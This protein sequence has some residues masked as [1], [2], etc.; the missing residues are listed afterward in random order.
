MAPKFSIHRLAVHYVDRKGNNLELAPT[1]LDIAQLE[2][3]VIQFLKSLMV[4]VWDAADSKRTVSA[5]YSEIGANV[6]VF[7][8]EA[9][10][11]IDDQPDFYQA[12]VRIARHLYAVTPN[13]ASDG[14]LVVSRVVVEN[15]PAYLV[16]LK[17]YK[18][19]ESFVR[20][21]SKN[22]TQITVEDVENLLDAKVQKAAISPHPTKPKF[23]VKVTDSQ[24]KGIDDPPAEY[25]SKQF[26]GLVSKK[27][28]DH[29][30]GN[31]VKHL[32]AYS[33]IHDLP[34]KTENTLPFF[35][36]LRA[37][38]RN[39]TSVFAATAAIESRLYGDAQIDRNDLVQFISSE[40]RLGELDIPQ[41]VLER[42]TP[43]NL[44]NAVITF[45]D[46]NLNKIRIVGPVDQ[47][48]RILSVDDG[49][50]QAQIL[51]RTLSST[52][53]IDYEK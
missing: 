36:R 31:L 8:T 47:L 10:A 43:K 26:L 19:D 50:N 39:V 18:R 13:Q 29:Q 52:I 37:E 27:S 53:Q 16:I 32:R 30:V 49:D 24:L 38:N 28:D 21:R 35:E 17:I 20:L 15:G 6:G 3:E 14:L 44:R 7:R 33:P 40:D 22:L 23:H 42:R 2:E 11:I 5:V 34:Y 9:E 12:S 41:G 48:R 1:A 4:K 51:I 25:F 45:T 46:P